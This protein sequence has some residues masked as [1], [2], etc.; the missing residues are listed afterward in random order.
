MGSTRRSMLAAL[1]GIGAASSF[2]AFTVPLRAGSMDPL[3]LPTAPL[4][5]ER[6]L[7]R[8]L[9]ETAAISVERSWT[10]QFE[11]QARGIILTGT[12][13]AAAVNAPPN[14]AELARIEQ[15]RN[16]STLFPIMLSETGLILSPAGTP[17][18]D[19]T[20]A[21]AVR[22]AEAIIARQSAPADE[23]ARKS[24]YLA[25]LHRAGSGALDT[26]PADLFFP[27][28]IPVERADTIT[29]ADG[30]TGSFSLTYIAQPQGDAPWLHR[31]ERRITTRVAGLER[32]SSEVWTLRPM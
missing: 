21:A 13:I 28:G 17:P 12:Q 14:L 10:V 25:L 32:G 30:L 6:R 1:L 11:R 4:R 2:A 16:A 5:L 22:A 15:Q 24:H 27:A 29:L 19:D 26:L 31:A 18:Y 8:M 20:V 9:D 7:E 3:R 23:R